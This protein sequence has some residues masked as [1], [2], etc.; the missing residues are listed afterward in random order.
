MKHHLLGAAFIISLACGAAVIP[1]LT[2][3][4]AART[5]AKKPVPKAAANGKDRIVS[6]APNGAVVAGNP[7]AQHVLIEYISYTC[8]HCAH[9][10]A[11]SEAPLKSY[12][13]SGKVKVEYRSL[14]RDPFDFSAALLAHCGTPA[15]FAGNH[16]LLLKNQESWMNKART[17]TP[18]QQNQWVQGD[19]STRMTHI[20]T[21]IGLVKLMQTR[22][23]TP[24]QLK[25]C[26]ADGSKQE[27]LLAMT[28]EAEKL[29]V[30][31]TPTFFLNGKM[32]G[33]HDWTGVN[34]DIRAAIN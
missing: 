5:P 10:A 28:E 33:N 17:A 24:T 22:G 11:E 30:E 18:A 34:S 31:G 27:Q 14:L 32:L 3:D 19:Y 12:L 4:V 16:A 26:L 2:D 23:F 29:G 9:F 21:D 7:A 20:A 13:A 6:E 15:Q 25:A 8:S 1:A